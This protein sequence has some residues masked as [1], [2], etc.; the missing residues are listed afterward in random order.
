MQVSYAIDQGISADRAAIL[1]MV[2]GA[3]TASG[4][5]L[6]GKIVQSGVLNRLHMHQLSMVV[7]GTGVM[8]LPLITSYI[9]KAFV[10]ATV[11]LKSLNYE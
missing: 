11:I 10:S 9:G 1:M 7:T 3:C 6:F 4:R 5:I 8:L 2:L